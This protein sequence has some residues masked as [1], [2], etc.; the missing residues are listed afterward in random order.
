M[1]LSVK[2]ILAAV[3]P[4]SLYVTGWNDVNTYTC[5]RPWRDEWRQNL[6]KTQEF[7]ALSHWI[8]SCTKNHFFKHYDFLSL[9]GTRHVIK[10][11]V[12]SCVYCLCSDW[13]K[14]FIRSC[15]W[16]GLRQEIERP[17]KA[18]GKDWRRRDAQGRRTSVCPFKLLSAISLVAFPGF[19]PACISRSSNRKEPS[20]IFWLYLFQKKI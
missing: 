12:V 10:T 19:C 2:V 4:F 7:Q 6:A 1:T 8:R 13:G 14:Q 15:D 17:K 3:S 16:S 20:C 11:I 5:Q 9:Y 18:E